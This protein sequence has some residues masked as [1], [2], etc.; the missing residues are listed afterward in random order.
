MRVANVCSRFEPTDT[1][2]TALGAL[3]GMHGLGR[4][5]VL[6]VFAVRCALSSESLSVLTII[7]ERIGY[8][9]PSM[10]EAVRR[11]VSVGRLMMNR[12]SYDELR[13]ELYELMDRLKKE[14][15][16]PAE[17]L[18]GL[19]FCEMQV[20]RWVYMANQRNE[21]VK[22]SDM[23]RHFRIT[24]SAA[25]QSIKKLES[26]GYVARMRSDADSRVVRLAL[27]DDGL[28]VAE[29]IQEKHVAFMNDLFEYVGVDNIEQLTK[30][31]RL[32]LEFLE[33]NPSLKRCDRKEGNPCA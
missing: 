27:T 7:D 28:D 9:G 31:L 20:L 11:G 33:Q 32:M 5:A 14:R 21:D 4:M 8:A 10:E 17:A 22:P 29:R 2:R 26:R 12:N 3:V 16:I 15:Y 13:V 25:S 6:C 1:T 23:A 30:T 19:T 24:P 18:C